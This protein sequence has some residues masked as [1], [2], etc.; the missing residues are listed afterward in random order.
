MKTADLTRCYPSESGGAIVSRKTEKIKVLGRKVDS[1]EFWLGGTC[2]AELA[3][4]KRQRCFI[5][6]EASAAGLKQL[7]YCIRKLPFSVEPNTE[8]GAG[9]I[10]LADIAD[11]VENS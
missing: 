6:V 3:G 2:P 7:L 10:A 4:G 8:V 11:T 1:E 9:E 5:E